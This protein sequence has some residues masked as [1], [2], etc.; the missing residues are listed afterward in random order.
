MG[1]EKTTKRARDILFWPRMTQEI[2][3]MI[4]ACNICQ[5]RREA[6]PK[7]P[8]TSHRI[9][10]G[11]WEVLA[12]DLFDYDGSV[13]VLVVDYYSRFFAIEK[14]PDER[15]ITVINKIKHILVT[16]GIPL[17]IVSD[18]G[19]Q[20]TSREF[21]VF[22]R[23]WGI[24][25]ITSS[26]IYPQSNGLA[27]RTVKT[28]K[29]LLDKAKASGNDPYLAMLEY[30]NMP[31]EDQASPAQLL[32]SRRTRSI[33]P[34]TQRQRRPVVIPPREVKRQRL[35]QQEH[36]KRYYDRGAHPLKPLQVGESARVRMNKIWQP[37]VVTDKVA[38]RS[39]V[40]RTEKGL[41]RRNRRDLYPMPIYTE[42][43]SATPELETPARHSEP[44]ITHCENTQN[45]QPTVPAT[46][47]KLTPAK[48]S[49]CRDKPVIETCATPRV[50]RYGRIV[51][52]PK[53]LAQDFVKL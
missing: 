48:S 53:H 16:H 21:Q 26:P 44:D 12:T 9:P 39:Y 25:H 51:K 24:Q 6:N 34:L 46:P 5:E 52:A 1:I 32:M 40:V 27:E 10:E 7:E 37:A 17:K 23:N 33:M 28:V 35:K 3:I 50:T 49:P 30:L 47:A 13:Y 42:P 11:P 20:Y 22:T 4:L 41:Y 36:Q 18:N 43:R 8:L 19:P 15:S 14:L 45:T 38:D 2:E 31:L 29:R